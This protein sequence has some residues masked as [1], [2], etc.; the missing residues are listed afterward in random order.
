MSLEINN[1]GITPQAAYHGIQSRQAEL[2][3]GGYPLVSKLPA[4]QVARDTAPAASEAMRE[5]VVA[6]QNAASQ[7]GNND[8]MKPVADGIARDL[9][10]ANGDVF[11][12]M[13]QINDLQNAFAYALES[14]GRLMDDPAL[15]GIA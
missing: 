2:Q 3:V 5:F 4:G 6:A 1:S 9:G 13:G 15:Q 10:R 8:P 12:A 7:I 11:G 14:T